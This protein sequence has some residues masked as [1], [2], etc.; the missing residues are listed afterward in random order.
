MKSSQKMMLKMLCIIKKKF[1]LFNVTNIKCGES[2]FNVV[3]L[4]L[5]LTV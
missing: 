3:E 2:P 5:A 4:Q 1:S